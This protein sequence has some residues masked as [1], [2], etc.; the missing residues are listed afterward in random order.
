[1]KITEGGKSDKLFRI[2]GL[3]TV[4]MHGSGWSGERAAAHGGR[5]SSLDMVPDFHLQDA[6]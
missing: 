1:M 3:K 6:P 5:L 4:F 2:A